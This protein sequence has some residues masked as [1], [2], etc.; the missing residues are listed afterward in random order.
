[1]T[2]I[3]QLEKAY[4]K[5][6]NTN[7]NIVFQYTT[8]IDIDIQLILDSK[9]IKKNMFYMKFPN[10][11]TAY[12]GFG[13]I[14]S[15]TLSKKND[16][17]KIIQ[18]KYITIN[19]NGQKL[20]FFGG[21]SFN[22][23]DKAFYPWNKIPKGEF[24]IPKILITEAN[25]KTK[26]TYSRLI[27]TSI[28]KKSILNDYNNTLS[29]IK[30]TSIYNTTPPKI[31]LN[32][33]KPKKHKYIKQI[34]FIIKK[35]KNTKLEKVV[36]SRLVKYSLKSKLYLNDLIKYF[37]KEYHNCF[38]FFICF[39][40]NTIF[41]GSTPERLINLKNNSYKIDAIAGSSKKE[42]DLKD[43]KEIDE[44]SYVTNHIH[45][46]MSKFSLKIN[47]TK[48]P[49]I[50]KLNYI[51]HLSSNISGT[52]KKNN[53]ILNILYDLYPTP[54]LLGNSSEAALECI[55][56]TETTDRG[57]YAGAIGTY[58]EN[59]DGEFYVPIRSGLIKNKSILLFSG[60]GIVLKSN[61]EK[62]WNETVLKLNHFLSFFN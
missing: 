57:W 62:E 7:N 2:F 10:C 33:E 12:L 55:K 23:N 26:L 22:L 30:K 38:N 6:G 24:H 54:A 36:I 50:L 58:N 45:T 18:K 9:K 43:S 53:H 31:K 29:K 51:N 60:S 37:N 28:Q 11:E 1:M 13:K 21:I 44:H 47:R 19:N 32:L 59:G 8:S 56:K 61:A 17:K 49:E 15:H 39:N 35:I 52:L 42:N 5:S 27:N 4:K 46:V 41:S 16:L 3:K 40:K 20:K 34:N 25:N 14:A 48:K